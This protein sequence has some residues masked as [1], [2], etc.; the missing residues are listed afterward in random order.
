MTDEV[1]LAEVVK[2]LLARMDSHPEEFQIGYNTQTNTPQISSTRWGHVLYRIHPFLN[3]TEKALFIERARAIVMNE[4]HAAALDELLNGPEQAKQ[5][6]IK[7]GP[8]VTGT[9]VTGKNPHTAVVD[10]MSVFVKAMKE[11]LFG[12]KND[13]DK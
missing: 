11:S 5:T 10:D 13:S 1:E 4:E 6:Y 7:T 3:E 12:G 9:T 8:T 2:L